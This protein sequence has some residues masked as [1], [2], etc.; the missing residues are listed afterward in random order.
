MANPKVSLVKCESYDSSKVEAAVR[1][2]VALLG[3]ITAFVKPNETVLIKPNLLTDTS[4]EA[5]IDTHPEVVRAVIRLLKTVTENIYCGDSPSVFVEKKGI[6]HVYE[7]SGIKKVCQ[8]EGVKLVYFTTPQFVQGYPLTDWLLKCDRLVSVPKFK[9]HGYTVLTAGVK[10]LLGLVVGMYKLKIH[11]DNPRSADLSRA[12]VDI[13]EIRRPD[14]T[15]LDGVVAMEGEGPGSSGTLKK[16]DLIAASDHAIAIDMI[17][18]VLMGLSPQQIPT[19]KEAIHRG[20][21]LPDLNA[22][23]II[24]EELEVFRSKNFKLPKTSSFNWMPSWMLDVA[25]VFFWIKPEILPKVCQDCRMCQKICPSRAM[26]RQGHR[27]E[28]DYKKCIFCFC[29]QEICPHK[30]IVVKKS[31]LWRLVTG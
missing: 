11:R 13:Y 27:A 3:S 24:G 31:F 30:A 16:M 28:I 15:I 4:P 5:G 29:C 1:K 2:S 21:I 6:E 9:T 19:N 20:L 25:K 8:E 12:L 23:E 17:L 14:L 10:N 22:I 18:A 26:G 7:I